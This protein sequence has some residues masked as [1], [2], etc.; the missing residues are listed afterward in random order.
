MKHKLCMYMVTMC[1]MLIL[2]GTAF[3]GEKAVIVGFHQKPGPSEK[4]LIHGAKGIIKRTFH[5]IPAMAVTLSEHAIANI[6]SSKNVAYVEADVIYSAAEPVPGDES[7]SSW[8]V[9][10]IGADIAH[11]SGNK[12]TGVSVAVID[13]GID[14]AHPDLDDNFIDGINFVQ[15]LDGTLDPLDFFDQSGN[16]HGTHVAGV[17]AAEENGFGVIGVAP[18]AH[19]YA[20]R[21]LDGAGFGLLSWII[22]GIE[23]AVENNVDIINLSIQGPHAQ[24]LEDA[25]AQ[26][27]NSGV[28]VVAA[29]GN[30]NGGSLL[31]PGA[32]D[33][34]IAVTGTDASDMKAYFSPIGPEV[35]LAAPGLSILSTVAG[36]VYDVL[37]GTSQASPHV[38]GVAALFYSMGILD[39]NGNG[40]IN[41]E[42]REMLQM[43]A[44]DLGD[45]G[46]DDIFGYG[47]V[48]AAA[49]SLP[50]NG[51]PPFTISR[52][53][54]SPDND[55]VTVSLSE[56]VYEITV[57]NNNLKKMHVD[58]FEGDSYLKKISSSIRFAKGGVQEVTFCLDA[59]GTM[60]DVDFTPSGKSGTSAEVVITERGVCME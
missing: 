30:T 60:Y 35:E 19:L 38:A 28:L 15:K 27:Y 43:T 42:V 2:T 10:H 58:V 55:M 56:A 25:C 57:Q 46:P 14:Y 16:S 33:S 32:Y 3:S 17:I 51:L 9:Q 11:I 48:D 1:T 8:G 18:E 49:A 44:I 41:D 59:T 45:P 52:T 39:E 34:V 23:W 13:T 12:G 36:G 22:S 54:G 29:G 31:Y 6:K 40:S 5:L 21:V 50:T 4:A 47:L 20:I 7:A 37:N 26:A 53:S 24:S